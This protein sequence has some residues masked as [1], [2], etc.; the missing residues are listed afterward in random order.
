MGLF[1]KTRG[2]DTS[3]PTGGKS[4]VFGAADSIKYRKYRNR[5]AGENSKVVPLKKGQWV[6]EGRPEN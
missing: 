6:K 5:L 4:S 2:S 3:M 1:K